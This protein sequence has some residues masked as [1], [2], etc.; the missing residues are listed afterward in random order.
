MSNAD[1]ENTITNR[2]FENQELDVRTMYAIW[3]GEKY[4]M[5]LRVQFCTARALRGREEFYGACD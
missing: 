1:D 5:A 2:I 4:G 3:R